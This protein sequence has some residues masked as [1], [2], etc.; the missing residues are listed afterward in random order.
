M[1]DRMM[2]RIIGLVGAILVLAGI[3]VGEAA[4]QGQPVKIGFSLPKTGIFAP[5]APSQESAYVLWRE[6]VNA[7]GGLDVAG[8]RR[9][10]EFVQYDDQSDPAKAVQIYEKLITDDKVDLVFAPWGTAHHFALAGLLERLKVP[11]M[12]NTAASVRIRELQAKYIWFPASGM[13]DDL[14]KGLADLMKTQ[15]VKTAAVLTLQLPFSLEVRQHVMPALE[16]A[17]IKVVASSD[18]PPTVKDMT[19]QLSSVKAAKPDAVLSLSYPS[20]SVLYMNQARSLGI[21][22]PFQ[23]VLIGPSIPFFG[24][25]FGPAADGIV[26]LGQW[27]PHQKKWPRAAPFY[28]AYK[29]R[30]NSEPDYLDTAIAYL[31]CEIVE[32]AVA[33]AGLDREKLRE[34]YATGTFETISGN[35]SFK[36]VQNTSPTVIAQ[37]QGGQTHIVWPPDLA[38]S[39]YQ[40]KGSWPKN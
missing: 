38:T 19:A 26:S 10:V 29:K 24:T 20:D 5:G 35:I 13:P 14:A 39:Q 40:P 15:N 1:L 33:K 28:E 18:Y 37:I 32:Q 9:P 34:T 22:A 31:S 23:L 6:Q 11:M 30:F 36:G 21:D 27:T 4:A 25:M 17:G 12:G 8:T 7:R 3:L 2:S 16:K